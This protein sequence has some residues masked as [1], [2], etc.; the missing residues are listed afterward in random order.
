MRQVCVVIPIHSS[1][2]NHSDLLS[3]KQCYKILGNYPI[4]I[5]APEGIDL[6]KYKNVIYDFEVVYINPK[7]LSTL[8]NYNRLKVSLFFYTLF[9]E[10]EF[11]LTYELDA[12]VIKDELKYWCDKNYDYIGAPWFEGFLTGA[13][14]S[15]MVGVGNSGFSLRNTKKCAEIISSFKL[16]PDREFRNYMIPVLNRSMPSIYFLK[17]FIYKILPKRTENYFLQNMYSISED[18]FWCLIIGR[19][20]PEFNIAPIEDAF[21]FSFE[22][23]PRLL[24]KVNNNQLP[25]GCHAWTRYDPDFWKPITKD[26]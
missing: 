8:S 15:K 9:K 16:D 12:Y 20:Y 10:Y 18:I 25:F 24:F 3:F 23:N 21:K 5:I 4:K 1:D 13:T 26:F 22:A 17:N 19:N 14:G 11:I 7:W 2:P 6:I